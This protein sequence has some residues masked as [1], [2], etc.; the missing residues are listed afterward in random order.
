MSP[1]R[2]C[3]TL[4]VDCDQTHRETSDPGLYNDARIQLFLEQLQDFVEPDRARQCD[5]DWG[6]VRDFADVVF[7]RRC[8]ALAVRSWD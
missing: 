6:P 4:T 1:Q 2:R 7:C 8:Q 3:G 5:H